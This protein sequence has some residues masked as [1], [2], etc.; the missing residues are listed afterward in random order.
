MEGSVWCWGDGPKPPIRTG[1][2]PKDADKPWQVDG[3]TDAIGVSLAIKH[4]CAVTTSGNVRC[5]GYVIGSSPAPSRRDGGPRGGPTHQFGLEL[6]GL[7]LSG[8]F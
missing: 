5:W 7:R 1:G 4:A 6:Q 8:R 2:A 3:I